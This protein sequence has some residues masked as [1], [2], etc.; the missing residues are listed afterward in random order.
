MPKTT[1]RKI[2]N[3]ILLVMII[4]FL[5][6][7][8]FLNKSIYFRKDYPLGLGYKIL[9]KLPRGFSLNKSFSIFSINE[10]KKFKIKA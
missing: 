5:Y 7:K 4:M 3:K 2:G 10:I 1:E 8:S 9:L 6:L